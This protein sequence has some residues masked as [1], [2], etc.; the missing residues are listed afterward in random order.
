[1]QGDGEGSDQGGGLGRLCSISG[2][3]EMMLKIDDLIAQLDRVEALPVNLATVT[4]I[5]HLREQIA[6]MRAAAL[7]AT[8]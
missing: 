2:N 8:P 1:M 5:I 7:R 4:A 3:R 6:T